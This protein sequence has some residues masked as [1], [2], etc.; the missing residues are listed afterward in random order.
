MNLP[1]ARLFVRW[2]RGEARETGRVHPEFLQRAWTIGG[3]MKQRALPRARKDY[4]SQELDDDV[5]NYNPQRHQ[6]RC[7]N[8]TAT[9]RME[10]M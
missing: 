3:G 1:D 2:T 7:L 6:G 9:G 4:L 5:V 8:S 10:A